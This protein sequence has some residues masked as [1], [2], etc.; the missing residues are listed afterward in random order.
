MSTADESRPVREEDAFDV[1][2]TAA[3]LREHAEA[4]RDDLEGTPDVRQFPGGASNLTYL[5]RYPGR[6]LILRR[7][8]AGA[9]A[10]SAHDMGRE[11]VIQR[12][13]APVYPTSRG[14][15]GCAATSR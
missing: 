9:K 7:P 6:D 12:A 13:L 1:E 2:A 14:W 3:W 8:P 10:K 11:Y 4:F 5:L 15:S